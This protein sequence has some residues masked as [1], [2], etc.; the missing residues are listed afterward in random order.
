MHTK[1]RGSFFKTS[2][3][4]QKYKQPGVETFDLWTHRT[5]TKVVS[6]FRKQS[7]TVMVSDD[8]IAQFNLYIGQTMLLFTTSGGNLGT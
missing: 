3:R 6:L 5:T 8:F 1:V 2:M 7:D 4:F